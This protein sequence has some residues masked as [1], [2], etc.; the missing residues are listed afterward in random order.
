MRPQTET[1]PHRTLGNPF[2]IVLV[3]YVLA[4]RLARLISWGDPTNTGGWVS[5][6]NC[7][8]P[9]SYP[10]TV[11][12]QPNGG[13]IQWFDPSPFTDPTPKF[14]NCGNGIVRGPGLK[15][16]DMGLKKDF[17]LGETRK[18]E[19]R[20]EFLNL[21]NTKIL[22]VP[23]VFADYSSATGLGRIQSSQGERNIQ[24]ALKFFF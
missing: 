1:A 24:L 23:S 6:P 9:V 10:K 11:V 20:S 16:F 5:R 12:T 19:F 14:G 3:E 2:L 8:G 4:V 22:N 7:T 18:L 21:T 13:G 15:N 17:S